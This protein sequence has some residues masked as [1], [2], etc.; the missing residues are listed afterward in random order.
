METVSGSLLNSVWY[1]NSGSC[2]LINPFTHS[3]NRGLTMECSPAPQQ[4]LSSPSPPASP[5]PD[6]DQ[7][8]LLTALQPQLLPHSDPSTHPL[9]LLCYPGRFSSCSA[10]ASVVSSCQVSGTSAYGE[11]DVLTKSLQM[12]VWRRQADRGLQ[13]ALLPAIC[14]DASPQPV[15][16]RALT[17][18][19]QANHP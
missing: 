16:G 13:Q 17:T 2:S 9:H 18:S 10:Q 3:F 15:P 7:A 12:H 8:P 14:V 1:P 19:E 5:V 4:S 6:P 11:T